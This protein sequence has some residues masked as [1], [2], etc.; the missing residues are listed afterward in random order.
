[1]NRWLVWRSQNE[2][3][4]VSSTYADHRCRRLCPDVFAHHLNSELS[5]LSRGR[6]DNIACLKLVKNLMLTSEAEK[7]IFS[8]YIYIV[9]AAVVSSAAKSSS[10]LFFTERWAFVIESYND[11]RSKIIINPPASIYK[12]LSIVRYSNEAK[13][14]FELFFRSHIIKQ[15]CNYLNILNLMTHIYTLSQN[16]CKKRI[17]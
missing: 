2:Y 12:L 16:A 9:I 17:T 7:Y 15:K 11:N 1:M 13:K 4:N 6:L 14:K 8:V 10:R 5:L 3:E